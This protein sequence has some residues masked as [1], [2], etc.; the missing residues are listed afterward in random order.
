MRLVIAAQYAVDARLVA[1]TLRLEPAKHVVIQL[2]P[3]SHLPGMNNFGARPLL[4]G[5]GTTV[6]M[7]H[8][9]GVR[10]DPTLPGETLPIRLPL[11]R[12]QGAIRLLSV[13]PAVDQ[14]GA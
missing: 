13:G 3:D 7:L 9:R 14:H 5:H 6:A 2:D 4:V 12:H 10:V 11:Q 1:F 8:G